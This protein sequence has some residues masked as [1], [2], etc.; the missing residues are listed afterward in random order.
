MFLKWGENGI[1]NFFIHPDDLKKRDFSK[2]L[3]N[4]DRS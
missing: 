1:A 4:W 3:Y 2:V